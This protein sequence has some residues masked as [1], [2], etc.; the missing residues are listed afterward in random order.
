[1]S[2]ETWEY[3]GK[4]DPY[5]AV[6]TFD[7]FRSEN[8]TDESKSEFF[9]TGEQQVARV[10]EEIEANLFPDFKPKCALDFGCGVGRIVLPFASRADTVVGVDISEAMLTETAR[11][12]ESRNVNNVELLQTSEFLSKPGLEF[13][14]IHSA[15][16]FQH[17]EPSHGMKIVKTLLERLSIGGIGVLHFTYSVQIARLQ[18]LQVDAYKR[19]PFLYDLKNRLKGQR[20]EPLMPIYVYDLNEIMS[21]LQANDCHNCF[22]RF[23]HHGHEGVVLFFQKR[24][25]PLF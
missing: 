14:L 25:L 10:F 17:I 7:Q 4:N 24:R 9:L 8:M 22:V 16:V 15:I 6:A 18:G 5:F 19:F 1:M 23:S 3:F 2:K 21:V 11:N 20:R 12:C 13:D